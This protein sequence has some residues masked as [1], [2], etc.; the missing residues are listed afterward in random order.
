MEGVAYRLNIHFPP[1]V[2]QYESLLVE[3]R[4]T[5]EAEAGKALREQEV[6]VIEEVTKQYSEQLREQLQRQVCARLRS[7]GSWSLSSSKIG[8]F[9]VSFSGVHSWCLILRLSYVLACPR[10]VFVTH[11]TVGGR[12]L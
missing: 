4:E 8:P 3:Q 2:C 5:L 10:L 7:V 6:R 12:H 1:L 11:Q 9:L